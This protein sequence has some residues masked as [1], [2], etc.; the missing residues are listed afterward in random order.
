MTRVA[1][2]GAL[3]LVCDTFSQKSP[4]T[5]VIVVSGDRKYV[6]GAK[7]KGITAVD[8]PLSADDLKKLVEAYQNS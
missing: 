6:A 8:K 3:K 1:L 7:A 5:Y 2:L 4:S